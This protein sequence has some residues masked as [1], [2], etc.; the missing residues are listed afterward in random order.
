MKEALAGPD[1]M[2]ALT[3]D[4][5]Q[6]FIGPFALKAPP[7]GS[8]YLDFERGLFGSSTLELREWMRKNGITTEVPSSEP[9]DHI[10]YMLLLLGFLADN[11]PDLIEEYL[12]GHLTT[13]A[14]RFCELLKDGAKTS[15]YRGLALL[16]DTTLRAI[17]ESLSIVTPTRR[18]YR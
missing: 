14:H 4:Y 9:E 5:Q 7:W 13:W 15:F 3:A 12:A 17:A 18:L 11:R 16:T 1:A 10:G 6:L 8:A 2:D